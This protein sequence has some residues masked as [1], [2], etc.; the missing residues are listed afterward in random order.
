MRGEESIAIGRQGEVFFESLL[1]RGWFLQS[2]TTDLGKDGLIV[3][4]DNTDLHNLEFSVQVKSSEKPSISNGSVVIRNV[5]KSSIYYWFAS[6]QPVMIVAVDLTQKKAWYSWHFELFHSPGDLE[7]G[8]KAA[9]IRIPTRSTLDAKSWDEIRTSVTK[10]YRSIHDA[11]TMNSS[12]IW[13]LSATNIINTSVRN[14]IKMRG[15]TIPTGTPSESEGISLLIEQQQHNN[16]LTGANK[17]INALECGS[18]LK[19]HLEYWKHSYCEM[20]VECFPYINTETTSASNQLGTNLAFKPEAIRKFRE[21]L[22]FSAFD[23]VDIL[24]RLPVFVTDEL[25]EDG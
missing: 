3:I 8:K 23:L 7:D 21:P 9:T 10:Y 25:P 1:P 13:L 2:P 6:T 22:F 14:L 15:S 5:S 24:T 16:V 19:K 18:P 20:V 11:L 17:C 12:S 4:R